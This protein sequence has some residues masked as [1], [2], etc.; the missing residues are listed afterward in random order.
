MEAPALSMD[1]SP[2]LRALLRQ[3]LRIVEGHAAGGMP[4]RASLPA[5]P[6]TVPGQHTSVNVLRRPSSRPVLGAASP[7]PLPQ[8]GVR[9]PSAPHDSRPNHWEMRVSALT[10]RNEQ[11]NSEVGKMTARLAEDGACAV[12]EDRERLLSETNKLLEETHRIAVQ[13]QELDRRKDQLQ[14]QSNKLLAETEH[15]ALQSQELAQEKAKLQAEAKEVQASREEVFA[16]HAELAKARHAHEEAVSKRE[17]AEVVDLCERAQAQSAV[18][19]PV[20]AA[21]PRIRNLLAEED[22]DA[23]AVQGSAPSEGRLR[24]LLTSPGTSS[25][26]LR[27]AIG[28]VEAL[29]EEARRELGSKQLRERRAAYEQLHAALE[30]GN[31]SE[32]E[33]AIAA[34][35]AAEVDSEDI[36]RAEAKLAELHALTSEERAAIANR[37]LEAKRKKEAFLL[38]KKDQDTALIEFLDSLEEGTRWQEWRDYAGR[39]LRRCAQELRA[40]KAEKVLV[41]RAAPPVTEHSKFRLSMGAARQVAEQGLSSMAAAPAETAVEATSSPSAAVQVAPVVHE[42]AQ[43]VRLASGEGAEKLPLTADE[44]AKLKAQALRAVVQDDCQSLNEVLDRAATDVWARWENKAGKDL[45]TL[46]QERGSTSAY[47]VL[48]KALGIVQELKRDAFEERETVWVFLPGEVQPLRATVL[49]DTPEDADTV[50]LEYWDGDAPPEHV[51]R[52]MI[53]KMWS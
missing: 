22:G 35:H 7:V 3:R 18:Q 43:E 42:P 39:T 19:R 30:K 5:R 37:D 26:Q 1:A 34:A 23:D 25:T 45:L 46:S 49:E 27:Q 20:L 50:E 12:S 29:L 33:I 14:V 53:R 2:E 31:E 13:T 47:A 6:V 15:L 40:A 48:A 24:A 52:S 21:A 38:V 10:L 11:L 36:L 41:D 16:L 8:T 9:A 4:L 32:L 17:S 51:D 44:E 28:A